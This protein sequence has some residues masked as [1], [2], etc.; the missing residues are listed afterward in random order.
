MLCRVLFGPIAGKQVYETGT[1]MIDE[2]RMP[3][4]LLG[5]GG[6]LDKS[7]NR[8][9]VGEHVDGAEHERSGGNTMKRLAFVLLAFCGALLGAPVHAQSYPTKPITIVFPS[10]RAGRLM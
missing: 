8:S 6:T 2:E 7:C 3:A 5:D 10:R 4:G 9:S 1:E